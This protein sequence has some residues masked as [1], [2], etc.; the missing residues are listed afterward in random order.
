MAP[1]SVGT[2]V[3][4][5]EDLT[6]AVE[7]SIGEEMP[8]EFGLMLDGWSHGTEH[9]LAVYACYDEPN[10]PCYPLL[11]MAPIMEEPDDQ[12]SADGH[13]LAIERF[14]PFFG[15]SIEGC[16]FL[17]GDNCSV[18][19]RL[20]NIMGVP[21]VGCASHR[22]NLAVRDYLAPH[23]PAL[24]EVQQLMRKLR[25]LKQAAKLRYRDLYFCIQ[26]IFVNVIVEYYFLVCDFFLVQIQNAAG[27][28]YASGHAL[29]LDILDA[30]ALLQ[31][32]GVPL[33]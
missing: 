1:V 18:N 12:L 8:D 24:E 6:K 14:L 33:S 13:L 16:K 26:F 2:L 20:A 17:V 9:F 3:S 23:E 22:L 10:G 29:G 19:K 25:T 21:L 4:N 7:R 28:N 27:T 15:K 11:S 31:A 30:E 32:E 5:M